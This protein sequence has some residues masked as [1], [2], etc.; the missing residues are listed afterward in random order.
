MLFCSETNHRKDCAIILRRACKSYGSSQV[1]DLLDLTVPKGNIY[2]L[3][4]ASGSGKT[5]LLSCLV[6]NRRLA[7]GEMRVLGTVPGQTGSASPGPRV[8]YMP[9]EN[10]LYQE[11]TVRETMKYFGWIAGLSTEDISRS[12]GKLAGLL[13]INNVDKYISAFSGG[14]QRR[15]SF[16]VVLLYSPEVLILD[17]PTVGLDPLL[18]ESVWQYLLNLAQVD[19]CTILLTTHYI[20]EARQAH[21]VGFMR[22]GYVVVEAPPLTL[23]KQFNVN[24]L[25]EAFLELSRQQN[26]SR[27][28]LVYRFTEEAMNDAGFGCALET[29]SA[30]SWQKVRA[31]VWKQFV[32]MSRNL[33]LLTFTVLSTS[34]SVA[35]FF[36]VYGHDPKSITVGV[37]NY[38]TN[39]TSCSPP[40][41]YSNSL[42]CNYVGLL[43]RGAH[44]RHLSTEG[45][46]LSLLA[47]GK[48]HALLV[49]ERNYS[50]TLREKI[51]TWT[52][53][54]EW[55]YDNAIIRVYRDFLA[56][57]IAAYV[58]RFT[59]EAFSDFIGLYLSSCNVSTKLM[60]LP[61][62]WK[63]PV[64][65][66][67]QVE[68]TT[69]G[70]PAFFLMTAFFVASM[71]T[72][73]SILIEKSERTYDR[74]FAMGVG[75]GEILVSHLITDFCLVLGQNAAMLVVAFCVF[76]LSSHGSL[77]TTASLVLANSFCGMCF[78][79]AIAS[80]LQVESSVM[81]LISGCMT[82]AILLSGT[83]WPRE[84]M[85]V[86]LQEAAWYLPVSH[87]AHS[88]NSILNRG[89]GWTNPSVYLGFVNCFV[90]IIICLIVCAFTMRYK[91]R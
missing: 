76:G 21:M 74:I 43:N 25:E 73:T 33:T 48:L 11:L 81:H 90:W 68:L 46:G 7:S 57:D 5:T 13:Q 65:G 16:A 19:S 36:L 56:K 75:H 77:I 86:V 30:S 10:A 15:I 53:I 89:W 54:M 59:T 72:S 32:A 3:L 47:S 20:E 58:Q 9:Q 24:T 84:G 88:I 2:A 41:C 27:K 39:T 26:D 37:A 14:E 66:G 85:H 80:I 6:G 60:D 42:S 71:V 82:P 62:Q 79:Y 22:K 51:M 38:E 67:K 40:D 4:G 12:L 31:L 17:E 61:I 78:G 69:N 91:Q 64:Y 87:A 23:L 44:L 83:L 63:D 29:N 50:R 35:I 70:A 34:M 49:I 52:P 8:G 1:L 45:E 28:R 18:R 55:R